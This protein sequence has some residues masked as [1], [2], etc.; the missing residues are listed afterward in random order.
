MTK[1]QI[2]G[3]D[4]RTKLVAGA[5]KVAKP[6]ALTLGPGGRLVALQQTY[7]PLDVT[8]DGVTVAKDVTP[9]EDAVENLGATLL[10]E[11]AIETNNAAGDGTTTATVLAQSMYKA[12]LE[13]MEGRN[14]NPVYLGQGIR[15]AVDFVIGELDSLKQKMK[16]AELYNVALISANYN[17][18]IADMLNLAINGGTVKPKDEEGEPVKHKGVGPDGMITVKEGRTHETTVEFMEGYEFKNGYEHMMFITDPERMVAEIENAYV[19]LYDGKLTRAKEVAKILEAIPEGERNVIFIADDVVGEAMATLVLNRLNGQ[20]QPVAVK[21]PGF[22]DRRKET[23]EDIAIATGGMVISAE[24]GYSLKGMS[25]DDLR[26]MLGR[27][28]Y[29]RVTKD[30][31]IILDSS[32][33][34][35]DIESRLKILAKQKESSSSDYE[36]EKIEERIARLAGKVAVIHVGAFTEAELKAK[37]YSVE[38][39]LNAVRAASAEGIVAGGGVAYLRLGQMLDAYIKKQKKLNPSMKEGMGIVA[40][41]LKQ[42]LYQIAYNAFG[43][44]VGED[45]EKSDEAT[46]AEAVLEKVSASES[47]SFGYDALN[48]EYC[49]NMLDKDVGIID[50]AL[51]VRSAI[52]NAASVA[53]NLLN[54]ECAVT[55]IPEKDA[56]PDLG[57][58]RMPGM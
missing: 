34:P 41:A 54:I 17:T 10:Q 1:E 42:P 45:A 47:P 46:Q 37:K 5:D 27:A 16:K 44:G 20:I 14:L 24:K 23:L 48:H 19:V 55:I 58:P 31:T 52:E 18:E 25:T 22:G 9:L 56:A 57:M 33:E 51:V 32:G 2:Y 40:K 50:P 3:T 28:G 43:G 36:K 8:K 11:A 21:A 38:D 30:N 6:V 29:V 53:I 39:A 12:G 15:Q 49:D 35:S 4:A 26:E 13:A 7:R